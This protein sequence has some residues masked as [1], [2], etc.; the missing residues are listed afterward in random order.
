MVGQSALGVQPFVTPV[1]PTG[2]PVVWIVGCS[3]MPP[4]PMV[5]EGRAGGPLGLERLQASN[6][7]S[8]NI[9]ANLVRHR[10]AHSSPVISLAILKPLGQ[11]TVQDEAIPT[12]L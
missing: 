11:A 7:A 3:A 12:T 5:G 8:M 2:C 4:G 9:A 1:P 6:A 10:I